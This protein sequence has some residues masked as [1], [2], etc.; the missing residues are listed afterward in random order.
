M[1]NTTTP[2][3]VTKSAMATV[4]THKAALINDAV[5]AAQDMP[6]LVAMLQT[7]DPTLA[8]QIEGKSLVASKTPWGTLVCSAVAFFATKYGLACTA[9]VTTNCWSND[10]VDL[11]GGL[12][13]MGGAL[14]GSY[15]MRSITSAPI[16]GVLT[17]GPPPGAVTTT[18]T[19]TVTPTAAP[20]VNAGTAG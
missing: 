4:E 2:I 20:V 7:A 6:H 10:T 3:S 12:A 13:A 19:T 14:V 11:V 16:T 17:K 9:A 5:K 1:S 8:Q 18:A 15:I